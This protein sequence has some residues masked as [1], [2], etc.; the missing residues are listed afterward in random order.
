MGATRPV[1]C[2][3]QSVGNPLLYNEKPILSRGFAE[4]VFRK[5][6]GKSV[7]NASSAVYN[8]RRQAENGRKTRGEKMDYIF[9]TIE[10][11]QNGSLTIRTDDTEKTT[12]YFTSEKQAIRQYR[13]ANGLRG[14]KLVKIYI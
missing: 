13:D 14:K 8:E 1:A 6:F 5:N 4:K 3:G 9:L 7:D 11:H 2:E 10:K 12:Y